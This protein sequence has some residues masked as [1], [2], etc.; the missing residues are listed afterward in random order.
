M[1]A[2]PKSAW[3][4][5][6][7]FAGVMILLAGVP[8][9]LPPIP[10]LT[11]AM[12]HMGRFRV[13]LDIGSSPWLGH[14][15]GF[16]W[17]LIG[18][19]GVDL[20]VQLLGPVIGLEP[21]VKLVVLAI[22][23]LCVAGL[24]AVAREI[25]GRVPATALFA[26]PLA[27]GYPFQFGFINFSLAMA[28]MLLAFALWLRLARTGRLRLR[29]V[30]FLFVGFAIWVAHSFAWGTLGIL[31][32]I[33]EVVR[34]RRQ[35]TAWIETTTRAVA[36]VLPLCPPGLLLLPWGGNA[37]PKGNFDWFDWLWKW[38]YLYSVLRERVEWWDKAGGALLYAVALSGL[39]RPARR[40]EATLGLAALLLVAIYVC[41]PRVLLSSAYA[42][43]RL[44]PYMLAMAILALRPVADRRLATG[45]AI[46]ATL[47]F[48]ARIA[49]TTGAF[50]RYERRF[51]QQ[52]VALDHVPMGARV[53][54]LATVPCRNVWYTTRMEH[55]SSMATVRRHSFVNDQ[56]AVPGAQLLRIHYRPAGRY[57]SHDPSQLLRDPRCRARNEP[58]LEKALAKFPRAA[59]D[60]VWMIDRPRELWLSDAGLR[61]VWEGGRFGVLYR[62]TGNQDG[63]PIA[64]SDTPTGSEARVT[65]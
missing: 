6:R 14:Y 21:A 10:P 18:N 29:P 28:L 2:S 48:V 54:A 24:L 53:L 40:Y 9:L 8:L 56:W 51:Q 38:R 65:R 59:F 20:L 11:D 37:A 45:V 16:R 34:E 47:F 7:A 41:L 64:S 3:W 62:I 5:T 17:A 4:E 26:L 57:F 33:A 43:M 63:S 22:P 58:L 35:R 39:V 60:Y 32:F 19:L 23:P 12:G 46:A 42:D 1:S 25:H 36:A 30:V 49:V 31:C 13:Q 61:P 44:V 27:Y 50:L 55:L 52:L 15:Y